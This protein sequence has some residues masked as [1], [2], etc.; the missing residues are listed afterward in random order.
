MLF[1]GIIYKH[2]GWFDNKNRAPGVLTNLISEDIIHLNGLTTETVSVIV[3]SVMGLIVSC[4]ICFK[5]EWR[6]AILCTG[7]SP[8][9]IMGGLL[10]G[11]L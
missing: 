8:F 4:I 11:R 2:I 9:M 1:K 6:L 10:V 7:L 5:F 3:E